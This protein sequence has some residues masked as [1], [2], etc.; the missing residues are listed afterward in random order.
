M[1]MPSMRWRHYCWYVSTKISVALTTLQNSWWKGATRPTWQ[2]TSTCVRTHEIDVHSTLRVGLR[3]ACALQWL[4]CKHCRRS[5]VSGFYS[6]LM[7][8]TLY[9][10]VC[11]ADP[12]SLMEATESLVWTVFVLVG[13][14]N[15]CM[16]SSVYCTNLRH[17]VRSDFILPLAFMDVDWTDIRWP[18]QWDVVT[19]SLSINVSPSAALCWNYKE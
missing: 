6:V 10:V 18:P 16:F 15:G 8:P 14:V 2:K 5:V 1:H 9:S 13:T 19:I 11:T 17:F 12:V 7:V 4:Q 3:L